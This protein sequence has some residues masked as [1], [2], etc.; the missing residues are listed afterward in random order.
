MGHGE[1]FVLLLFKRLFDIGKGCLLA[2]WWCHRGHVHS[3]CLEA[4]LERV[5]EVAS[6]EN[7]GILASLDQVRRHN[8]PSKGTTAANNE[9]L[10]GRGCGQEEL[11]EER[12][13]FPEGI[14]E[15]RRDMAL[16]VI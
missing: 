11:A 9:G 6:L 16:T 15:G 8:V 5:S 7:Q 2:N 3:V 4:C 14:N 1:D 10:C 12:Q 13:C